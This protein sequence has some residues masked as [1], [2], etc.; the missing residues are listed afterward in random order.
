MELPTRR[1]IIILTGAIGCTLFVLA[2]GAAEISELPEGPN[3]DLVSKLCQ[4]C[5]D[6]QMVYDGA[7]FS[8]DEWDMTLDEMTANGMNVSADERSKILTY[9][10]TYL[11]PSPPKGATS[12]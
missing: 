7:G 9:L 4:S 8:R 10:T 2:V 11:G 1:A 12:H 5:H 3:R 6:L